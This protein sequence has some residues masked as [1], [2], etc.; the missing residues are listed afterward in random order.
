MERFIIRYPNGKMRQQKGI[1]STYHDLLGIGVIA[2]II[3]T[4]TGEIMYGDDDDTVQ[5]TKISTF[6][7]A[8][9]IV[10]KD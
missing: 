10:P 2:W 5:K 6:Q 7:S 9:L 3:D 1:N 4:K 8:D